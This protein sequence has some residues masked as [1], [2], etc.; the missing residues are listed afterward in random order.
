VKIVACWNVKGGV[1]KT[2][3]AVN[4]AYANAAAGRSTL[5][6]DLDEQGGS[7]RILGHDDVAA[8]RPRRT[9]RLADHVLEAQWH[10]VSLVPA[11]A[12]VHLLD[13]HDRPKRVRELL[14]RI[15]D[16]FDRVILDC[17][18]SLGYLS[19]QIIEAADLIVVP[20]VP[21]TLARAAFTQLAALASARADGGPALLP[22]HSLVD[23]RRGAHRAALEAEPDWTAIPYSVA[24][25][26]M[27]DARQP[28]ALAA[29][30]STVAEPLARLADGVEKQLR[31]LDRAAVRRAA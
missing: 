25:E 4:L 11:D 12:L 28:I 23:R 15:A 3:V 1:G 7:S 26:A 19:E 2:S 5:L 13:R 16:R 20:I 29:S 8:G 22:V 10:G 30:R 17:P 24:M 18:P 27:V 31:M 21:A 6:W 14:D 9:S